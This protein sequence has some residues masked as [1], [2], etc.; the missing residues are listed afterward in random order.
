MIITEDEKKV[1]ANLFFNKCVNGNHFDICGINHFYEFLNGATK[2]LYQD[3]M[4]EKFKDYKMLA[5]FHALSY[6]D[7]PQETK[8]KIIKATKDIF[9]EMGYEVTLKQTK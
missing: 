1:A 8:V 5:K 6:S 3:G 2:N 4:H 9:E 7:F